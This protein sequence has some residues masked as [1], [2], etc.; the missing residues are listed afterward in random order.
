MKKLASI[1]F[2]LVFGLA[3]CGGV[4]QSTAPTASARPAPTST[5]FVTPTIIAPTATP[6]PSPQPSA[7]KTSLAAATGSVLSHSEIIHAIEQKNYA[8]LCDG[9]DL[10]P[11]M[12]Q[13][14]D[15]KWVAVPCGFFTKITR[16]DGTRSW[17][18]SREDVLSDD[19]FMPDLF[20]RMWSQDGKYLYLTLFQC[21]V[22]GPGGIS[23]HDRGLY[24]L[25]LASGDLAVILA[26]SPHPDLSFYTFDL[27]Q[28]YLVYSKQDVGNKVFVR[29]L[30]SES[31][32]EALLDRD[33]PVI[34]DFV[35]NADGK[36]IF[37]AGEILGW[38]DGSNGFSLLSLNLEK[39][40]VSV[41]LDNDPRLF[42]PQQ[43]LG[44]NQLLLV[45][46]DNKYWIF[47]TAKRNIKATSKPDQ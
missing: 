25:D 27:S 43:L 31:E 42:L 21:C 8:K 20:T 18:I 37:F 47:D 5:I 45:D 35:W 34:G 10:H 41:L 4:V 16:I 36:T 23:L 9:H 13:S 11:T 40:S 14:P 39:M 46:L 44:P 19:P 33:Y 32:S 12:D 22:D 26:V 38:G 30:A 28:D 2:L 3:A 6:T 29:D 1:T 17:V 24:R 15:G 7:T